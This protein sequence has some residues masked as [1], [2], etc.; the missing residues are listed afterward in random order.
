MLDEIASHLSRNFGGQ[1]PF[2]PA[3]NTTGAIQTK[4]VF[5]KDPWIH[6]N[7]DILYVPIMSI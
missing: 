3:K 1:R 2:P 7:K 5:M 6:A 4:T